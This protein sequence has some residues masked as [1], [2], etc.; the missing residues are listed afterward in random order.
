MKGAQGWE[1]KFWGSGGRRERGREK[2]RGGK[3][4]GGGGRP[5]KYFF[6]EPRLGPCRNSAMAFR[7]KNYNGVATRRCKPHTG[8]PD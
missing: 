6:L 4:Y 5:P 8:I 7:T 1:G 3:I 2:G